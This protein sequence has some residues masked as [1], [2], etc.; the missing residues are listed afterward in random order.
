MT[1]SFDFPF[2]VNFGD[3]SVY[4]HVI[5]EFLAF[6]VGFRYY[7][8]LRKRSSDSISNQNRIFILVG[9]TAGALVF[10]RLIGA[11]ESPSQFFSGDESIEYY[12]INKT[13]IGGLIGGLISVEFVK[14]LI[15]EK[16]SSGDLFTYPIILALIIGRFGCFS[17]GVYEPTYGNES[18]FFTGMDLGDGLKRHPTTLYEIFYL[19]LLWVSLKFVEQKLVFVNGARFKFFMVS[20]F[21]FRGIIEFIRPGERLL[22]LTVIQISCL[23]GLIYYYKVWLHPQK[24]IL[25][26]KSK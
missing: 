3:V 12:L 8:F 4:L 18:D 6:I 26:A 2:S 23:L 20:L 11:L 13:I 21:L 15:G 22:G 10:S 9:A 5:L 16:T 1:F 19:I 7:V 14:R 24:Q 17:M 25:H